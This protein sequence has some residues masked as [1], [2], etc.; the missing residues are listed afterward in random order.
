MTRK[1]LLS[2]VLTVVSL[3][4]WA[5]LDALEQAYELGLNQVRLPAHSASQVVVRSCA[6]CAPVLLPV[7][8]ETR[9]YLK[10]GQ[11]AVALDKFLAEAASRPRDGLV[12][13]F[14]KPEDGSVTRIVLGG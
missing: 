7:S 11:P 1:F 5:A 2:V 12:T 9:Y 10:Y 4:A 14:Y 13:V 8:T 3:P 6:D